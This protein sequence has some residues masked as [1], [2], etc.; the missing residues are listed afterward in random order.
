VIGHGRFY[1]EDPG[2]DGYPDAPQVSTMVHLFQTEA[3]AKA[4][5]AWQPSAPWHAGFHPEVDPLPAG[6]SDS[7]LVTSTP[8]QDH[9]RWRVEVA[10]V[11]RGPLVGEVVV[12][13][14]DSWTSKVKAAVLGAALGK[15]M[16]SVTPT[17]RPFDAVEV[18]SAPLTLDDWR[19][20]DRGDKG[21]SALTM[22]WFWPPSWSGD[23]SRRSWHYDARQWA[24]T[25]VAADASQRGT[26]RSLLL[27]PGEDL[28][29][30]AGG[31]EL[32]VYRSRAAA[33]AALEDTVETGLAAPGGERFE[34][35]TVDGAVG[36]QHWTPEE[37]EFI[38]Y[39]WNVY[40]T[41]GPALA[42]AFIAGGPTDWES[43]TEEAATWERNKQW[44]VDAATAWQDRLDR[45]LG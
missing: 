40:F 33:A 20:L 45:V 14:P 4:F 11:R 5:L 19:S 18:I 12:S 9:Q 23:E 24:G 41:H 22:N 26:Y 37:E 27:S 17:G 10:L 25:E 38:G 43:D 30:P 35:P 6:G 1:R 16:D 21:Y 28:G 42:R 29:F 8:V 15:R 32:T 7:V 39:T 31:T 34:V 44:A 13:G 36:V 2:N 3:G